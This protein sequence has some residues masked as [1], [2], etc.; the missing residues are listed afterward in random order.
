MVD[1]VGAG[2]GTRHAVL[3]LLQ[4][5]Y[6][7]RI[8]TA[9]KPESEPLFLHC[10]VSLTS[11]SNARPT[12]VRAAAVGSKQMRGCFGAGVPALDGNRLTGF[13]LVPGGTE[14]VA[15]KLISF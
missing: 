12:K 10:T 13:S 2:K 9:S 8:E 3:S 5:T 11:A 15:R 6:E 4:Y 14:R 7:P 1:R